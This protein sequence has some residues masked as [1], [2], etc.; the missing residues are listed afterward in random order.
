MMKSWESGARGESGKE[1]ARESFDDYDVMETALRGLELVA[2]NKT[3][4]A[5][6]AEFRR[7][8]RLEERGENTGAEEKNEAVEENYDKDWEA[9]EDY[10]DYEDDWEEDDDW[11]YDL[12]AERQEEKEREHKFELLTI[13]TEILQ[14]YN[15]PDDL[16][17]GGWQ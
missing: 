13:P 6:I 8:A 4:A 11:E 12:G 10:D 16:P 15:L 9:D 1:S 14:E 5:V 17:K 7:K 2:A 3:K